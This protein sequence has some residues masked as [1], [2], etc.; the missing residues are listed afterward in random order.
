MIFTIQKT[1]L[2]VVRFLGLLTLYVGALT[3][4]GVLKAGRTS[5]RW[6]AGSVPKSTAAPTANSPPGETLP[7]PDS[8]VDADPASR[9]ID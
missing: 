2:G 1:V 8:E 5:Y 3:G 9:R 4:I 6:L 7:E